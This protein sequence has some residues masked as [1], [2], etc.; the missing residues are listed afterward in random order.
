MAQPDPTTIANLT[1]C[2]RLPGFYPGGYVDEFIRAI[3]FQEAGGYGRTVQINR[4][5]TLGDT[6][7]YNPDAAVPAVQGTT[8]LTTFTFERLGGLAQ[9]DSADIDASGEPNNQL[10]LQVE[11]RKVSLLRTLSTLMIF[12]NGVAPQMSGLLNQTDAGQQFDLAGVAPTLKDYHRLVALVRASDGFVGTGAD[13]LVMNFT[14]RRQLTALLEAAGCCTTYEPDELLG[15]PVLKFDGA[16]VYVTEGIPLTPDE[17]T[18]F[19]V[20][21]KGSTG[22]RMLHVGGDS[23]EFGIVIDDVPN[24]MTVSQRAKTVRGY[25]ALFVPEVQS[26]AAITSAGIAAFVP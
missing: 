24:Q 14:A 22:V 11:M 10:D 17:T 16:S 9:V 8:G 1:R 7:F 23:E 21:L 4:S 26:V 6:N 25:Y 15:A 3:S 12:G 18:I 13:A 2:L 20:K 5:A 19:A